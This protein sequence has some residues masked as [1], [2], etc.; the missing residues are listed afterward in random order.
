LAGIAPDAG[1][2]EDPA[3]REAL[4]LPGVSGLPRPGPRA[5]PAIISEFSRPIQ[6]LEIIE[7]SFPEAR[8]GPFD[9]ALVAYR[10]GS[11]KLHWASDGRHRLYDLTRD[12]GEEDD[13]AAARPERTAALAAQVESWLRRAG[14]RP[15]LALPPR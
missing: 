3:A 13:L 11:E 9:R 15:P 7:Q 4:P 14:A 2:G 5:A 12:P 10:V 8:I 6:F 1:A